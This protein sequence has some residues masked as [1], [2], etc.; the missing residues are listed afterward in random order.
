MLV[1]FTIGVCAVSYLM[2]INTFLMY[3]S[4]IVGIAILKGIS[5]NDFKDVFNLRKAKKIYY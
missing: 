2:N 5:S 3:F 4:C 1:L